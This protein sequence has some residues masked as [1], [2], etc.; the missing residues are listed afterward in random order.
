[1]KLTFRGWKLKNDKVVRSI[2]L[3]SGST[4][5]VPQHQADLYRKATGY[6]GKMTPQY[7]RSY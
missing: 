5:N 7:D 2:E 6:K 4:E 1:M 3:D